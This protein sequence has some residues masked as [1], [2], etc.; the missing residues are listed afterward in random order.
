[1]KYWNDGKKIEFWER[2]DHWNAILI[3]F[4]ISKPFFLFEEESIFMCSISS[5]AFRLLELKCWMNKDIFK[6]I[7]N[8]HSITASSWQKKIKILFSI[9]LFKLEGRWRKKTKK[10]VSD[11]WHKRETWITIGIIFR[12][13]LSFISKEMKI[14]F[15]FSKMLLNSISFQGAFN[16]SYRCFRFSA[17]SNFAESFSILIKFIRKILL[18]CWE[19]SWGYFVEMW[20]VLIPG[21]V[22]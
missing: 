11:I 15:A 13:R 2:F 12:F 5:R 19:I 18:N 14:F 6:C 8:S 1:M 3:F 22:W 21:N 17:N 10:E 7:A 9:R 20:E 16:H 4:S